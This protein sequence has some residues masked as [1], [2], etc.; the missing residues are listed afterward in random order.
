VFLGRVRGY[1][2]REIGTT[3]FVGGLAML[4]SVPIA[5]RLSQRV[6][7]RILVTLGLL[8]FAAGLGLFSFMTPEWGFA[9]LLWPQAV[10]GFAI[11][12]CVVPSVTLALT[13]F[14]TTELRYASGLFNLMRN[15]GG[16]IGIALMITGLRDQASLH[17]LRFGE[18]MSAAGR[19]APDMIEMLARRT[20]ALTPD[21]S[22]ALLIA[23]AQFAQVAERYVLT[24]AFND[25]FRLMA[26][27][28]VAALLMVPFCGPPSQ[29]SANFPAVRR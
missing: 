8:I 19:T 3:V 7:P 18:A 28:F 13:G 20:A 17:A 24:L 21:T 22:H 16:G 29:H 1:N 2:S 15:L 4:L 12:L 6:D 25:V 14:A 5:S 9:A 27:M 11:M 26:W 23:Q 10:R